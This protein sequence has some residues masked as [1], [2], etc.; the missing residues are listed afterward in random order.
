MSVKFVGSQYYGN[1][2]HEVQLGYPESK[3]HVCSGTL[4]R[5][6][7]KDFGEKLCVWISSLVI[8][9]EKIQSLQAK[10]QDQ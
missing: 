2:V 8:T 9:D 6:G 3:T 1:Q 7:V 10:N 4:E 5:A